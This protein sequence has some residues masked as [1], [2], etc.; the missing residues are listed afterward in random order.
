MSPHAPSLRVVAAPEGLLTGWCR[1]FLGWPGGN[2]ER[3]KCL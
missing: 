1:G 2:P 3:I